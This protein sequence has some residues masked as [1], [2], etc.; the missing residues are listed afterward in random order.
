MPHDHVTERYALNGMVVSNL[1]FEVP[2]AHPRLAG[3]T[4]AR[5]D[6]TISVFAREVVA[7]EKRDADLPTLVFFQGGPGGAAPRPETRSGWLGKALEGHRVLLLDQRGTGLS[8]PVTSETLP[9]EGDAAA[10]AAYL[11][12]FRA[13]AIVEDAE[14]IR[15]E[16]L[17][18]RPWRALGQ[19]YGGFVLLRYLSAAPEG[20]EAALITG[21]IPSL[22]RTAE[23]VYRATYPRVEAKNRALFARYPHAQAL[24]RRVADHLREHDVRL[25]DGQRL[26]VEQFQLLGIGLGTSTGAA[27]L[28]DLLERALV[29]VGGRESV[30]YAFLHGVMAASSFHTSPIYSL[31]HEAI[32]GQG[33]ATAWAAQRVRAEFPAFDDAPGRPFRFT[34]EMVYPWMF[35]QLAPL[36][37]LRGAAEA[38]AAKE[39]WPALYDLDRLAA[40]RVPVS[41][42]VYHDDMYVDVGLSLETAARVPHVA[43]WVTN[44]YEHDGVRADGARVLERLLATLPAVLG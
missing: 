21:G 44:E 20:L 14:A 18:D 35:E 41:A 19:S 1:R 28:V 43:T 23:E 3:G 24:A 13:D 39:D 6:G 26:T 5:G 17:G 36:R 15:R 2:L 25:P 4:P 8:T 37:P 30:G 9:A 34:G 7:A 12:H 11:A 16:L 22:T 31:L 32:Y 27:R 10:Q 29:D 38:L 33:R 42:A 40:N